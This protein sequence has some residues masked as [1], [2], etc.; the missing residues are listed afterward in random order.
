[1]RK[2]QNVPINQNIPSVCANTDFAPGP[3]RATGARCLREDDTQVVLVSLCNPM[4]PKDCRLTR[5]EVNTLY[6]R[7]TRV[8]SPILGAVF[9][10]GQRSKIGVSVASK[11]VGKAT[12]RNRIRRRI[13][14]AI[15]AYPDDL[16]GSLLIFVRKDVS[17][18]RFDWISN[19]VWRLISRVHRKV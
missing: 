19:E 4:L 8:T 2:C 1:M 17:D 9:M 7:G 5:A 13:F 18:E 16:S 3:P 12:T 10:K 11:V 6:T 15:S 14:D